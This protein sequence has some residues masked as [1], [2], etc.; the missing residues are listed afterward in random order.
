MFAGTSAVNIPKQSPAIMIRARNSHPFILSYFLL[1]QKLY[2]P[3]N[4]SANITYNS[5]PTEPPKDIGKQNSFGPYCINHAFTT[6]A[7]FFFR[8]ESSNR[9]NPKEITILITHNI[10]DFFMLLFSCFSSFTLNKEIMAIK[11]SRNPITLIYP[12]RA[13]KIPTGINSMGSVFSSRMDAIHSNEAAQNK[14]YKQSG[15]R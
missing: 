5:I 6:L 8:Q 3:S 11:K 13:V 4:S 2:I 15:E 12:I 1:Y 10:T 14:R 7:K 9:N